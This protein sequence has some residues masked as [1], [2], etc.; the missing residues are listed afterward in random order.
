MSHSDCECVG[1]WW[2][3]GVKKK[4]QKVTLSL[5]IHEQSTNNIS[6]EA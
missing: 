4:K 5:C 3:N 1:E 6:K 2:V